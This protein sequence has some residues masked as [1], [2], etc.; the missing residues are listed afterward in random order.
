MAAILSRPQCEYNCVISFALTKI[1]H[2]DAERG[3]VGRSQYTRH[4]LGPV[5][6]DMYGQVYPL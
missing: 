6:M 4:P 3:E 1:Q 5:G 2:V